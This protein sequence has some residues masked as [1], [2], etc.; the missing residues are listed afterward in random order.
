VFGLKKQ[1]RVA[2]MVK[3]LLAADG[4]ALNEV[5]CG[6]RFLRCGLLRR[7]NLQTSK[8]VFSNKYLRVV[9]TQ[10]FRKN[11]IIFNKKRNNRDSSHGLN[12]WVSSRYLS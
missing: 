8:N 1:T 5:R 4:S 11:K 3:K 7:N 10:V 6:K 9:K 2:L 12:T